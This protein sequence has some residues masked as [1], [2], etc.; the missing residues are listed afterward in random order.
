MNYVEWKMIFLQSVLV[1]PAFAVCNDEE[2]KLLLMIQ[3][4]KMASNFI[5]IHILLCKC[6]GQ[7][8]LIDNWYITGTYWS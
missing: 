3:I 4:Y 8:L 1:F 7:N 5:C 2:N 6:I